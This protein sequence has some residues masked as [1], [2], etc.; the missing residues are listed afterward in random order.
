[1]AL[2]MNGYSTISTAAFTR[3]NSTDQRERRLLLSSTINVFVS[4]DN[5]VTNQI[6]L[7]SETASHLLDLGIR[8]PCD[9]YV[10]PTYSDT[11]MRAALFSLDPGESR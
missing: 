6:V 3:L 5:G 1:M 11:T 7:F 4:F 10:K 2:E 8:K 9:V